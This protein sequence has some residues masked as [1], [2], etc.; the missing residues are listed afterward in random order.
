[1]RGDIEEDPRRGGLSLI[2]V[3]NPPKFREGVQGK[4]RL[5]VKKYQVNTVALAVK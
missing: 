1:M 5:Q 2:W 4:K 3:K